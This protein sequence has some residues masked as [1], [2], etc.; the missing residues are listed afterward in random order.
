M[1]MATVVI[2]MV[3]NVGV[4]GVVGCSDDD[5]DADGADD[6]G[7]HDDGEKPPHFSR[8]NVIPE[9]SVAFPFASTFSP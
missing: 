7:G 4:V 8:G 6:D 2:T 1:K 3:V 5:V 9:N